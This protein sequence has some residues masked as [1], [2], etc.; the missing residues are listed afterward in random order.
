MPATVLPVRTRQWEARRSSNK[1]CS[2]VGET[3]P[4]RTEG[5]VSPADAGLSRREPCQDFRAGEKGVLRLAVVSLAR[6]KLGETEWEAGCWG[7]PDASELL[8]VPGG[9]VLPHPPQGAALGGT[10][11][12]ALVHRRG[13][14]CMGTSG[15][16]A[17]GC[18]LSPMPTALSCETWPLGCPFSHC[19]SWISC[20]P[21]L[22]EVSRFMEVPRC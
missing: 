18:F 16:S 6:R 3:G 11:L 19:D 5:F 2:P 8:C 17:G 10:V 22:R 12:P 15:G 9:G 20:A 13:G 14:K 7:A 1:A 4:F 21:Q